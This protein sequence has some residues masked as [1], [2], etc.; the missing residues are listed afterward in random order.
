MLGRAWYRRM[1][2]MWAAGLVLPGRE[3]K[4]CPEAAVTAPLSRMPGS[5]TPKLVGPC[6][7]RWRVNSVSFMQVE[8]NKKGD[9]EATELS[10]LGPPSM[11]TERFTFPSSESRVLLQ[12]GQAGSGRKVTLLQVLTLT[13]ELVWWEMCHLD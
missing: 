1:L 3:K 4:G 8:E 2:L 11:M 7:S 12:D 13:R 5:L 6:V 9:E 10:G